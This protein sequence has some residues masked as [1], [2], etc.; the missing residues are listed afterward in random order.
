MKYGRL[1]F[2]KKQKKFVSRIQIFLDNRLSPDTSFVLVSSLPLK[3]YLLHIYQSKRS[4]LEH[5]ISQTK[6]TFLF[7]NDMVGTC[8]FLVSPYNPPVTPGSGVTPVRSGTP[9]PTRSHDERF[10]LVG[11]LASMGMWSGPAAS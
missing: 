11:S 9:E 4:K 1:K 10:G 7:H 8:K 6:Q 2:V 3:S 5:G